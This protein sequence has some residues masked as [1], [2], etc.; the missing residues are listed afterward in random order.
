VSVH[1]YEDDII[2]VHGAHPEYLTLL[3]NLVF[4]VYVLNGAPCTM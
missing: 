2:I 1:C 3:Y 4:A